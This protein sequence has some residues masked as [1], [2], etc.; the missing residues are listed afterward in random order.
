LPITDRFYTMTLKLVLISITVL[1]LL[2]WERKLPFFRFGKSIGSLVATN[3][4]LGAVNSIIAS[5]IVGFISQYLPIDR[6]SLGIFAALPSPVIAGVLAFL[7]LDIYMYL[8]HRSMHRLPVAWRFHRLHHTDRSMN[9]S[10]AYRFH[11]I[12]IISSSIPKLLLIG[13]LGITSNIVLIY[14][15]VFTV[16]VALHHSNVC[17][18]A[19]VDRLL[20]YA[21]VTPNY[22][23]IHHSQVVT[24]T[25]ANYGSVLTWW[26]RILGSYRDRED[27][28]SIQLGVSDEDRELNIWQLLLL[29]ISGANRAKSNDSVVVEKY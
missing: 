1:S 26:D 15:L 2:V 16:V 4:E 29:P 3:L 23:R 6:A 5:A 7:L 10:T 24:E 14:E 25:N 21:I 28:E 12:E 18:P 20:S 8:W 13:V 9:V 11:P 17:L 19:R 22:H 27:I